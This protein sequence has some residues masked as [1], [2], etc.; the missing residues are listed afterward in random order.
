MLSPLYA[1]VLSYWFLG[2]PWLCVEYAGAALSLTGE[3]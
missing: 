3:W 2:E 1:A